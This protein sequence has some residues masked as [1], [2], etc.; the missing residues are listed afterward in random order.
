MNQGGKQERF[1]TGNRKPETGERC[2]DVTRTLSFSGFKQFLFSAL[3][4]LVPSIA[5]AQSDAQPIQEF[6]K[7][8]D[9]WQ[10]LEG[11]AFRLEGQYRS[12]SKNLLRF[13]KCDLSFWGKT[14]YPRLS[15]T[16]QTVEVVGRLS[17]R[18]GKLVFTVDR[19]T[20]L[21][22]DLETFREMQSKL[23]N[24][25]HDDWYKLGN[26]AQNRGKFYEDDKLLERS[27]YAYNKGIAL[28]YDL[29]KGEKPDGYFTL[30]N[31]IASFELPDAMAEEFT[32]EGYW[33][34]FSNVSKTDV[35]EM[36]AL[37]KELKDKLPGSIIPID[38]PT[39]K[40]RAE[41]L[42][43]PITTYKK[44]DKFT[45]RQLHRM[46]YSELQLAMILIPVVKDGSNGF[47]IA[48]A[49]DKDVPEKAALAEQYRDRELDYKLANV[50]KFPRQEMQALS[51]QFETR[52]Q[53]EKARETIAKWVE[54]RAKTILD[55]NDDDDR[56]EL[57]ND[58][59]N[60]LGDQKRCIEILIATHK[61]NSRNEEVANRLGELG[62]V[63][64]GDEWLTKDEAGDIPK[65]KPKQKALV[66]TGDSIA[67]VRR[68]LGDPTSVSK[69]ASRQY[70]L[71]VWIFREE[72]VPKIAIHFR[73][74]RRDTEFTVINVSPIRD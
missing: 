15:R 60:L 12:I 21:P 22:S 72:N 28:E 48:A 65:T 40:T 8:K 41:Y 57:A 13:K 7:L 68:L 1:E 36:T 31:R 43:A 24:P 61:A 73:K 47:E 4:V 66:E 33:V 52:K 74:A 34:A 6:L 44:S 10:K 14:D 16:S 59:L 49:I 46:L 18:N 35:K 55:G 71:Q 54:A 3:I 25:K 30:A 45:R 29:L 11:S 63:L 20:E 56:L 32:H 62:Y 51:K 2:A 23:D 26:W 64:V 39:P 58:Y 70:I 19:L 50:S 53:P 9:K 37:L 27:R 67:D 38:P 42:K 69:I 5:A 17:R